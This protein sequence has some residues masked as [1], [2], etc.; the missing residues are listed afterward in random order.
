MKFHYRWFC[1]VVGLGTIL[2]TEVSCR[3]P[4]EDSF[5]ESFEE[6]SSNERPLRKSL[7]PAEDAILTFVNQLVNTGYASSKISLNRIEKENQKRR[8][9]G[10]QL[11]QFLARL[12]SL[13][14]SE[15]PLEEKQTPKP[16]KYSY[17]K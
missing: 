3:I 1:V 12:S 2:V 5:D 17:Q 7:R 4:K 9:F 6:S 13:G 10:D 16:Q 8:Q 15:T 11:E 14:S